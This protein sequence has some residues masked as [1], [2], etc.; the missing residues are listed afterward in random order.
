[1]AGT[2]G[3]APGGHEA[4]GRSLM[5]FGTIDA[6]TGLCR[7]R[8]VAALCY[9]GAVATRLEGGSWREARGPLLGE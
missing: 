7:S 6:Y 3:D 8:R 2:H 1:M 4:D 5:F 9:G